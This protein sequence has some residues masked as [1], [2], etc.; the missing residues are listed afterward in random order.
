MGKQDEVAPAGQVVRDHRVEVAEKKRIVMRA[1]LVDATMRVI[2][3]AGNSAPVIDDV[4]REAKVSRGTF[5]NYFNTLDDVLALI[6]HELNDQMTTEIL[7]IYDMLT[8]PWQRFAVGF[9][10]F[11]VRAMFDHKWAG[12]VT[13][14]D[15]WNQD[16]L[17]DK[18]MGKD[19][20][21]GKAAG[22]FFFDDL[23]VAKDFLKGANLLGIRTIRQGVDDPI[24]YINAAVIMAFASQGCSR[25]RCEEGAAFSSA[26]LREWGRGELAAGRPPWALNIN[27]KQGRLFAGLVGAPEKK[28]RAGRQS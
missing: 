16:T 21:D 4:I 28:Q 17:V 27:S 1:R 3:D 13:R 20:A 18:Y 11:L 24:A 5:Y 26:H 19:L 12:F 23:Q 14:T 25:E 15:A 2:G 6:G 8:V 22:Q 10:V 9:R 7:P